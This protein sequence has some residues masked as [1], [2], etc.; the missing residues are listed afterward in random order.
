MSSVRYNQ[1]G[2]VGSSMSKGAACAYDDGLTTWSKLPKRLRRGLPAA[3]AE[4]LMIYAEWHHTSKFANETP[5][6]WPEA[7]EAF[8]EALGEMTTA[9]LRKYLELR[10][11]FA[12]NTEAQHKWVLGMLQIVVPAVNAAQAVNEQMEDDR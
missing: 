1:R 5:F 11:R 2:Y 9:E 4:A 6:Y 10:F 7:V 3:D 12:R 8:W